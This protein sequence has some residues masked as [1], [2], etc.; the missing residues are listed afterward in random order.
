[1]REGGEAGNG[2]GAAS[3]DPRRLYSTSQLT[4]KQLVN[5]ALGVRWRIMDD[6]MTEEEEA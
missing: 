1:V 4:L 3:G 6:T 5:M 2:V